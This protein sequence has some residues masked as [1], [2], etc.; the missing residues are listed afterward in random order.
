MD[1]VR[2]EVKKRARKVAKLIVRQGKTAPEAMRAAGYSDAQ[3][4][5]G[6]PELLRRKTIRTALAKEVE[7][8]AAETDGLPG[9]AERAKMI[10]W[11]LTKNILTGKDAAVASCK[12]AGMDREVN[13]YQPDSQNNVMV[14][15]F[16]NDFDWS[17]K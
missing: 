2:S 15:Q 1:V 3:S 10:R 8:F 16:P 5:K 17:E 11:R 13:L 6:F 14:V 7:K 4:A 9:A 12:L